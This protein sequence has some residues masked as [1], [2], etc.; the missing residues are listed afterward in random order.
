MSASDEAG[1]DTQGQ[2]MLS[3]QLPA[4]ILVGL[5]GYGASSGLFN[6][7]LRRLGCTVLL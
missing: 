7:Y 4:V 2:D 3:T 5:T 6:N 1:N